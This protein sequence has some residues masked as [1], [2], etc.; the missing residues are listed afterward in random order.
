VLFVNGEPFDD[1]AHVKHTHVMSESTPARSA[2]SR[3]RARDDYGPFVVP[4]DNYFMMGDNRDNSY[5][6]RNFGPV[7]RELIVAKA[8]FLYMSWDS[9]LHPQPEVSPDRPLS[10]LNRFLHDIR[11]APSR[12]RWSRI[13]DSLM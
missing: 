13:G 11:Y 3:R 9:E 4:P 6:S 10:Y 7:P 1:P 2:H 8:L 12:V 5:D